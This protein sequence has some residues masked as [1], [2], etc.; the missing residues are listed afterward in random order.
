M[1]ATKLR[2]QFIGD[3]FPVSVT[4]H[5]AGFTAV[6]NSIHVCTGTLSVQ[7][8]APANRSQIV[9]KSLGSNTITLVR[10]GTEQIEGVSANY[11]FTST[12]QSVTIV[13]NGTNW[14][15]I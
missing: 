14:F 5:G 9:I 4:T 15:I 1:S 2:P 3:L 11:V 10:A 6:H 13:S 8:P 12:D 7:L